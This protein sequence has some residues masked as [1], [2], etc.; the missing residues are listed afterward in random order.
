MDQ[1]G[2][3]GDAVSITLLVDNG[4]PHV[5]LTDRWW[6]WESG[7]LDV[8][9]NYFPIAS[10]RVMISDLQ[11]RWPAVV[12]E[13]NP[14]KIPG[15]I[16]WDRRFADRTLAPS[17]EYRAVAIACDIHDL[18]GS[19]TGTIAIPFV[20][21]ST[22]TKTPSLIATM[23]GTPEVTFTA[24]QKPATSTP[25]LIAPLPEISPKP[26]E[27]TKPIPFWQLLGLLGLFLA[28][29]SVSVIDPR[30]TALDRLRESIRLISKQSNINS[31]GNDE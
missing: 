28:I 3:L 26:A 19:D 5:S 2:N 17:G 4:P 10:V 18:C 22:V 13:F 23:T 11:N 12:M 9:P 31:S 27:P 20:A 6:I 8:S 25:V 16:S 30:P 7:K 1:A 21:T 14:D 15:S 29:S 24:T